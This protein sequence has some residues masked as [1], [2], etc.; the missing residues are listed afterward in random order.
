MIRRHNPSTVWPVPQTF[1][2]IY[3]HAVEFTGPGKLLFISGQIGISPDGTALETFRDQCIQAMANVEAILASADFSIAEILRLNY[4]LTNPAHLPE[5][6][7][8]RMLRWGQFEP[9]AVT[10]IIVAALARPDLLVEIEATA[11][12]SATIK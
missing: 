7:E 11:G 1:Q 8:I 6:T 9:P 2:N 5:L 12:T 4:F 3:S 10:T